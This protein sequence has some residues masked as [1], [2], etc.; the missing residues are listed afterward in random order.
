MAPLFRD[1]VTALLGA[2]CNVD[3]VAEIDN[4]L[5]IEQRLQALAPELVLIGLGGGEGDEIGAALAGSVPCARLIAFSRDK[6]H[7]FVHQLHRPR[8]VLLDISSRELIDAA[9]GRD[10]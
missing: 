5:A 10:G 3:L 9:L 1:L 2:H 8:R 7:A 6:R 4:R